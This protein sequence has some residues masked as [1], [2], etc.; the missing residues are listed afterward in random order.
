MCRC[1]ALNV[2]NY[3]VASLCNPLFL[4]ILNYSLKVVSLFSERPLYRKGPFM[5]WAREAWLIRSSKTY[6]LSH[7][8]TKPNIDSTWLRTAA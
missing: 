5:V 7:M 4:K 2:I 3:V 1:Y 8:F 6:S